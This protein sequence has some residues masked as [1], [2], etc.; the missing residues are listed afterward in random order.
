MAGTWSPDSWRGKP[1]KQV[2]VYPDAERLAAVEKELSG[3]PKIGRAH[4]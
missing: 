1:I 2:P 4:V 3:Y